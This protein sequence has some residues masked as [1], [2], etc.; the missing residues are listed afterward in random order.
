MGKLH[1]PKGLKVKPQVHLAGSNPWG[2]TAFAKKY[3][4]TFSSTV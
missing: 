1:F 3:G 4:W 2:Q